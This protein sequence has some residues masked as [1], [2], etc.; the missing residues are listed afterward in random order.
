[1]S[2]KPSKLLVD[3]KNSILKKTI[4]PV[5]LEAEDPAAI[6]QV[7]ADMIYN[8]YF[9]R[10]GPGVGIAAPQIGVDKRIII[11][12]S[13]AQREC[14]I[15]PVITKRWGGQSSMKEGCLS[16]PGQF[17]KKTRYKRITVEGYDI[18]FEKQV[19]KL[20]DFAARIVQHEVDHL[21]GVTIT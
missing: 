19:W 8:L 18:N 6:K 2:E 4:T 11:F 12:V 15:N 21:N 16:F 9:G 14:I 7:I 20:K 10:S 1:M 13:G 17:I 5:N 3:S